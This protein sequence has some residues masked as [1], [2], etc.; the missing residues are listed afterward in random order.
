MEQGRLI[1][2]AFLVAAFASL[3]GLAADQERAPET[4]YRSLLDDLGPQPN[5]KSLAASSVD[6]R[7]CN[8]GGGPVVDF[9]TT[10]VKSLYDLKTP[11]TD[12]RVGDPFG[13]HVNDY[14]TVNVADLYTL[15]SALADSSDPAIKLIELS[16]ASAEA[17]EDP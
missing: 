3:A 13:C 10:D 4:R 2:V 1:R 15:T 16:I 6:F 8:G 9:W 11:E 17:G 14:W 12:A 7:G 5:L